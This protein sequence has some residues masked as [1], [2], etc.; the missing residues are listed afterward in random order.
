MDKFSI[1][2]YNLSFYNSSCEYIFHFYF[3]M[4]IGV[5]YSKQCLEENTA[6]R[7]CYDD[8]GGDDKD[9]DD[10]DVKTVGHFCSLYISLKLN[11]S[12]SK[13][14]PNAYS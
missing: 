12:F 11:N 10:D 1:G 8:N 2:Y 4:L 6:M 14:S 5:M 3:M 9:D 7:V 13:I